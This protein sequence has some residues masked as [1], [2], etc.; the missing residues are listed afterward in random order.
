MR[1]E[2]KNLSAEALDQLSDSS[3]ASSRT[4]SRA[5]SFART[6]RSVSDGHQNPL[7]IISESNA[8]QSNTQAEIQIAEPSATPSQPIADANAD[9]LNIDRSNAETAAVTIN[10]ADE[11]S[12]HGDDDNRQ[13]VQ[14]RLTPAVNRR[15]VFQTVI[16]R[17]LLACTDAYI[18][19]L[20]RVQL[21]Q[22]LA[23][24]QRNWDK[25]ELE[26]LA[27]VSD[28]LEA[29]NQQNTEIY[30]DVDE[31]YGEIMAKLRAKEA[32]F[33]RADEAARVQNVGEANAR[34]L[35]LTINTPDVL[36]NVKETWGKFSGD[37]AKWQNFRNLFMAGVH[38]NDKILPVHKFQ[39]L[40][41][42]L[43]GEAERVVGSW[44]IT[45]ANYEKAWQRLC[46]NYD[47]DYLAVQ[48]ILNR[49]LN[50]QKLK[51]PTHDALRGL[52]NLIHECTNQLAAYID[53]AGCSTLFV[54][55]V[56]NK[57][58]G[59]TFGRWESHRQTLTAEAQ[60]AE[61]AAAKICDI[62]ALIK[63]TDFLETQVRIRMHTQNHDEEEEQMQPRSRES[64]SNRSRN[65]D[66][67]TSNV[68]PIDR[69]N[70]NFPNATQVTPKYPPCILCRQ[71]HG[72]YNC[73]L[74]RQKDLASRERFKDENNLCEICLKE[75]GR[76]AC[77]QERRDCVRC[78][79]KGVAHNSWLCKT[80]EA[81][82]RTALM[83]VVGN[84]PQPLS[85]QTYLRNQP[86]WD[87]KRTA[88]D[89]PGGQGEQS[90]Q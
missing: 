52:V 36:G 87:R 73:S 80:R 88:A 79:I 7:P 39:L 69:Q 61:G 53:V 59:V 32:E 22:D 24:L 1:I 89:N 28:E 60:E 86:R 33:L 70:R 84:T 66:R 37:F 15:T 19:D 48:T 31:N 62:P 12:E 65:A 34:P 90:D 82:N 30:N 2:L 51:Q 40:K 81:E 83:S 18:G 20:T 3:R 68:R 35:H 64:S 58:D 9:N 46:K 57:L 75:H 16:L 42:A 63:L 74:F 67:N 4:S 29:E 77:T 25:F 56:V 10:M 8:E 38:N 26:H 6:E 27:V 85:M 11:H 55:L 76:G 5:S 71:N 41:N 50:F 14:M 44:Q 72:L 43:E 23:K 49:L 54:F 21:S 17:Q 45:P 13:P 47:D 78:G